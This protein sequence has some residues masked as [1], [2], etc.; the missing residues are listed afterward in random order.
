MINERWLKISAFIPIFGTI[1][2]CLIIFLS[3][4]KNGTV[5]LKK[6]LMCMMVCG[7]VFACSAIAGAGV[8]NV[9]ARVLGISVLSYVKM[10]IVFFFSGFVMNIVF[11]KWY[12]ETFR[13]KK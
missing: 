5:R 12:N 3:H 1:V 10:G 11:L 4:I 2:N 6:L 9:I 7:I 13:L 8:F